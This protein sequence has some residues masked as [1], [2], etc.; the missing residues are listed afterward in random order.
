MFTETTTTKNKDDKLLMDILKEKDIIAGIKVD[1]GLEDI[2]G[3]TE[4]YTKG[5]DTL[6]A[7]CKEH[8]ERGCRFAKWRAVLKI[9]NDCP[10]TAAIEENANGLARYAA[11][12][13]ANGLVP[14]VEPEIL[15]DGDH[16]IDK[17][18]E[19]SEKVFSA[20]MSKLL[21]YGVLLEG[22]LLKP[23]MVTP[24]IDCSTRA[25]HAQVAWMT[26]RTLTRSV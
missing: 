23:N 16:S 17:C 15:Q 13:Q 18:A 20:V 21:L 1:K 3:T 7:F 8:Y 2:V 6:D 9:T 4:K 5:L 12:C 10:S 22:I 25:D 26:V 24:G 14:I 19:V 11:I